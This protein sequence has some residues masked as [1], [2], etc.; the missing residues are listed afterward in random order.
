MQIGKKGMVPWQ[1]QRAVKNS[2]SHKRKRE[3]IATSFLM[4]GVGALGYG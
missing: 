1:H 2:P 3:N 4:E